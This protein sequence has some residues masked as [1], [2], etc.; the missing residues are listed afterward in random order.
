MAFTKF[1]FL[2]NTLKESTLNV[3]LEVFCAINKVNGKTNIALM[4]FAP[5]KHLSNI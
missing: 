2:Y 1:S 5:R 4:K 3:Y